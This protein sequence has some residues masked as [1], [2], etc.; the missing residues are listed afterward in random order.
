MVGQG[1]RVDRVILVGGGARSEAVRRLA[2]AI[3]AHPVTVPPAGEYVADGAARQAAWVLTG[4]LPD[5]TRGGTETF[6]ADPAPAVREQ[7]AAV[8]DMTAVRGGGPAVPG[9]SNP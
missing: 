3:L 7:Y 2:P 1:V 9:S 5:W 8:R 4:E 6:E